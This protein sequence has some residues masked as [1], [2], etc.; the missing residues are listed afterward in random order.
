MDFKWN[1]G[2]LREGIKKFPTQAQAQR[3]FGQKNDEGNKR[4][5]M[6]AGL[7]NF[8]IPPVDWRGGYPTEVRVNMVGGN[9]MD[10]DEPLPSIPVPLPSLPHGPP[11]GGPW[12]QGA[13]VRK[14]HSLFYS[15]MCPYQL[16]WQCIYLFQRWQISWHG[17]RQRGPPYQLRTGR[18][19]LGKEA[20]WRIPRPRALR[21]RQFQHPPGHGNPLR[22]IPRTKLH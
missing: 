16:Q 4:K 19:Y 18:N 6:Q 2:I 15:Q 20:K 7:S 13:Q 5:L 9:G 21:P 12:W 14:F 17:T 11:G 8:F 3:F 10:E 22:H 1:R